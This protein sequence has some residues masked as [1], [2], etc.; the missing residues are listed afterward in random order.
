MTFKYMADVLLIHGAYQWAYFIYRLYCIFTLASPPALC[1]I[2]CHYRHM[3]HSLTENAP[4]AATA[5]KKNPDVIVTQANQTTLFR[6][7]NQKV[8][9]WLREHYASTSGSVTGDTE[10]Y[11]HPTRYKRI[12]EE[13]KSAGFEILISQLPKQ[14]DQR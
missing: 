7:Q 6:M 3:K 4:L 8:S 11:V 10:I 12:I 2:S 13:L 14:N 5:G 9:R 1:E